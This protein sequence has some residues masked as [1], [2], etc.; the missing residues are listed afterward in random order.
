MKIHGASQ[1]AKIVSSREKR[2]KKQL[3]VPPEIGK[4]GIVITRLTLLPH[5]LKFVRDFYLQYHQ[6]NGTVE[7][8][9]YFPMKLYDIWDLFQDQ[10]GI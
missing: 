1:A 5:F 4:E 2:G 7:E 9:T 6:G 3:P 10:S 8:G